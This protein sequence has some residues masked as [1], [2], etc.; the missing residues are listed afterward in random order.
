MKGWQGEV[1]WVQYPFSDDPRKY[2][3]RPAVVISHSRA[4]QTDHDVVLLPVTSR[5][6]NDDFSFLLEDNHLQEGPLPKPSEIRC[7]KPA[8]VRQERIIGHLNEL[9]DQSLQS[10]LK[11]ARQV[12]DNDKN[13][14]LRE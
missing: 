6:K 14:Q 13:A 11:L 4:R 5:I 7:N 2:K 8:T 1:V 9:T 12:F 3:Y 10:V